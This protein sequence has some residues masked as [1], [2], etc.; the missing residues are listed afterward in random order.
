MPDRTP[1]KAHSIAALAAI[2]EPLRAS[3]KRIVH[4]HGVFDLLHIG[5]IR[6]L[7]KARRLGD[8]LVV[9]VTPDRFV[10][11]GPHR[12]VFHES[13]RRDGVAALECVDYVAL[14]EWPTA[15]EAIK[16]LRPVVYAK[17]AEFLDHKRPELRREERAVGEVGGRVEFIDEV[18]SSSSSLINTYLAPVPPE[19]ERYLAEFRGRHSDED[20]FGYLEAARKLKVLVVGEA[21]VDEYAY[22]SVIGQS[23]KSPTVAAKFESLD[24]FAGGAV[25]VANHVA[26]FCDGVD[27]F[28]MLG[29][30][31]SR[32]EWLRGELRENVSPTFHYKRAAPTIVKRRYH[33]SYF[34]STV[35]AVHVYDDVP[36]DDD[37]QSAV[38]RALETT[39]G[40][41]DLVIVAD[42]GHGFL[43]ETAIRALDGRS[44][45]LAVATQADPAN[46]GLHTISRYPRAD[47]V[48]I[49]RQDLELE[50]RRPSG[51]ARTMLREVHAKLH[52]R[53]ATVT[54]GKSGCL[55][56]ARE[57]GFDEAAGLGTH[58]VDRI[59]AG[60]AFYSIASLCA[61]IDAPP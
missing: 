17:G 5:H 6:Y 42:Y 35:F 29:E 43:T 11:K 25:A 38:G 58:V 36:M 53:I 16:R 45:Y 52:A 31:D 8:L 21:V 24:R 15:V 12:P 59:G 44:R 2:V 14:N 49:S 33:E 19:V 27:V 28:A 50:C 23:M 61:A 9:T 57:S 18:T 56:Y 10:N 60:E 20:V 32:E 39:C 22:C 48:C 13:L 40:D 51:D 7:Q 1:D 30:V 47:Y 46:F 3:G 4:C 34:E 55:C 37:E 41:Y 26:G 54:L